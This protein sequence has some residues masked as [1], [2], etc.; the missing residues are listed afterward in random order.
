MENW[1]FGV[2]SLFAN[3]ERQ[4]SQ[5]VPLTHARACLGVCWSMDAQPSDLPE[6]AW[7]D[8]MFVAR[9]RE[10]SGILIVAHG[11]QDAS[12]LWSYL[13][14]A[15][16]AIVAVDS[17]FLPYRPAFGRVHSGRTVILRRHP[18]Q[19][20]YVLVEDCWPPARQEALPVSVVERARWSE[21]PRVAQQEPI[22]SGVPI[23]GDW[24]SLDC[25]DISDITPA[26]LRI[27]LADLYEDA[28]APAVESE[29]CLPA[30]SLEEIACSLL[31]REHESIALHRIASLAL[32]ASLSTRA[33]LLALTALAAER[34][35]D[36]WL[37]CEIEHYAA[38]LQALA[39]ARDL[40][41]KMLTFSR[42]I[43]PQIVA[44]R[45]RSGAEGERRLM[46]ALEPYGRCYL[47][48]QAVA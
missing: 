41:T 39:E 18:L 21:V 38:S 30:Q 24:W 6:Y 37:G 26:W 1:A 16:S 45:L 13:A 23:R 5:H 17:Y 43:Y 15:A 10:R 22:F 3:M 35:E 8:P 28:L 12:Q 11:G 44:Q 32:R 40:L 9:L 29:R 14:A 2:S 48:A 36:G 20:D 27:R 7:P 33:Y 46:T 31:E 42:P 47:G 19:A 25:A 34:L 4:L